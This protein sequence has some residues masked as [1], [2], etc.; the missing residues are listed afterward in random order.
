MLVMV[1]TG[2]VSTSSS[3]ITALPVFLVETGYSRDME[4]EADGYALDYM[5]RNGI[6]PEYFASMMDKLEA[7]Y[8]HTYDKCIKN[9]GT[10]PACLD[11][12]LKELRQ[13]RDDSDLVESYFS[14]HPMSKDRSARFRH[15]SQ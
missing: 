15:P 9:E 14:T 2:D 13:N 3:V 7:R 11:A 12:A 4:W 10:V 5:Q 6:D 1:V 8:T